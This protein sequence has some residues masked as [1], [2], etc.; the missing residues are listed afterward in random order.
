MQR[1]WRYFE[2]FDS[3]PVRGSTKTVSSF[4]ASR[5]NAL[6]LGVLLRIISLHLI[7]PAERCMG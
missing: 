7:D 1:S 5:P 3:K 4:L 2:F 6:K